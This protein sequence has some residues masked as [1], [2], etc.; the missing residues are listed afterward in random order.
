[1]LAQQ[2]PL[3]A[4][5]CQAVQSSSMRAGPMVPCPHHHLTSL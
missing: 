2:L 3:I 5:S 1:M 4:L